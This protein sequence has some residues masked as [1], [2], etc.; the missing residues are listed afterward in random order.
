MKPQIIKHLEFITD[1]WSYQKQTDQEKSMVLHR[2]LTT[3]GYKDVGEIKKLT[4]PYKGRGINCSIERIH[5]IMLSKEY[6]YFV[7]PSGKTLCYNL[8]T[9]KIK[10]I[11]LNAKSNPV[12]IWLWK[13]YEHLC[14][15]MAIRKCL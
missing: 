12:K 9:K 10:F 11:N 4:F 6:L 3:I 15:M 2:Y 8:E 7:F 13:M 1:H 14:S 5:R